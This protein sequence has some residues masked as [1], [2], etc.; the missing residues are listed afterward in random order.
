[1]DVTTFKIIFF[2]LFAIGC[3]TGCWAHMKVFTAHEALGNYE[4]RKPK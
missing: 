4:E 2:V 3:A 1:M